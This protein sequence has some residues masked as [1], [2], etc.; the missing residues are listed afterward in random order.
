MLR[1][2]NYAAM[3]AL[4]VALAVRGNSD[5]GMTPGNPGM[6]RPNFARGIGGHSPRPKEFLIRS[7]DILGATS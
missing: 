3:A 1:L 4:A 5:R 7:I 6:A 2:A